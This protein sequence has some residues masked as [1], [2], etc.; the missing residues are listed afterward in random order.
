[1]SAFKIKYSKKLTNLYSDI[2][3]ILMKRTNEKW[4]IDPLLKYILCT[5]SKS[6]S[7][8]SFHAWFGSQLRRKL[9][10]PAYRFMFFFSPVSALLPNICEKKTIY[11]TADIRARAGQEAGAFLGRGDVEPDGT[12]G[13]L[14]LGDPPAEI[15]YAPADLGD[16]APQQSELTPHPWALGEFLAGVPR[17]EHLGDLAL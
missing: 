4:K 16:V 5:V 17:P 8:L 12:K 6:L 13:G 7:S 2:N 1:M 11:L 3:F 15:T 9:V 10:P 14:D